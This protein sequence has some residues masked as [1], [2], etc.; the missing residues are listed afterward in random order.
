VA[1]HPAFKDPAIWA[2]KRKPK[3]SRRLNLFNVL[4]DPFHIVL[5]IPDVLMED[6]PSTI[7]ATQRA[8]FEQAEVK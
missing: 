1:R 5:S 2:R 7:R 6:W 8:V 3:Y 4:A